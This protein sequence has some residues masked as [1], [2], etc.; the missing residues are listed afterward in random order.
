[1]KVVTR[2][3]KKILK[4]MAARYDRPLLNTA[5]A[6][7]ILG[8]DDAALADLRRLVRRVPESFDGWKQLGALLEKRGD[9]AG[10]LTAYRRSARLLPTDPAVRRAVTRL[11]T[12]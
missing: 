2:T 12:R 10:A 5:R 7:E 8:D 3:Q 11:R 9:R 1:M 6:H 4:F